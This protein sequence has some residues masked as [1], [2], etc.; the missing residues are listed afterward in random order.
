MLA[1]TSSPPPPAETPAQGPVLNGPLPGTLVL[2]EPLVEPPSRK[3][4]PMPAPVLERRRRWELFA[5]GLGI[6]LVTY[7][8]DRLVGRDLTTSGL[9]W[10]P[11]AGP[12]L[13]FDE[14]L[15]L[16]ERNPALLAGLFIDGLL[17]A[18]GLVIAGLGLTWPRRRQVLSLPMLPAD[19][20]SPPP[21]Q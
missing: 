15:R 18:G 12:W 8:A 11:V 21:R 19:A 4:E 10:I 3:T 1:Q 9:D 6:T 14:Q 13:V 16:A 2:P 5:G 17:Q 20:A 7:T